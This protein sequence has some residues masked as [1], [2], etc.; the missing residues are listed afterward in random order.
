MIK[1][2]TFK[3]D[4]K[5]FNYLLHGLQVKEAANELSTT[6]H[7]VYDAVERLR[8]VYSNPCFPKF[9]EVERFLTLL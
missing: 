5:I 3:R 6:T 7:V 1:L 8:D 2:C 9:S 4:K